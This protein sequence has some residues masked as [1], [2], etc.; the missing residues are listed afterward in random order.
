MFN[1]DLF[2]SICEKYN[3]ELSEKFDCPMINDETG[4]HKITKED[5]ERNLFLIEKL[6][7]NKK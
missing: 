7:G 4:T 2:Y 1:K 3:V 5:V 6:Q